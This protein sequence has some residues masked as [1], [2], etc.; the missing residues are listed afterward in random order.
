ML[1]VDKR[2]TFPNCSKLTEASFLGV[3]GQSVVDSA[4]DIDYFWL[5]DR[6]NVTLSRFLDEHHNFAWRK[7]AVERD[8]VA[9]GKVFAFAVVTC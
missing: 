1:E 8:L 6:L 2:K 9:G 7:F 4:G 3:D 5:V